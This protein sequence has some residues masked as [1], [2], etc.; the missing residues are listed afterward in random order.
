MSIKNRYI[1]RAKITEAEFRKIIKYFADEMSAT[2]IAEKLSINR[3]T[4]NKYINQIRERMVDFSQQHSPLLNEEIKNNVLNKI[5]T[6]LDF[7]KRRGKVYVDI[8]TQY[9]NDAV[10]HIKQKY[11]KDESIVI[12]SVD[13]NE[14]K[15]LVA[16]GYDNDNR[17][18]NQNSYVS[19][20]EKFWL[21]MKERTVKFHGLSKHKLYTHIKESEFRF[22]FRNDD[23]YQVLLKL[24]HSNPIK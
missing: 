5:S 20:L 15:G 16:I 13:I 6:S 1:Y 23:L 11:S 10:E 12:H 7:I 18:K 19:D 4:I 2:Q 22:N 9:K 14:E 24:I 8:L 3:N 21:F 17:F